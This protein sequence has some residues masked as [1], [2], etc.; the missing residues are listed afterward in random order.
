MAHL[1]TPRIRVILANGA[2]PDEGTEHIV[3]VLNV[4]M[5]AFDRDRG[6]FGWPD[7]RAAPMLW[8]TYLAWKALQRTGTLAQLPLAE[9]E[10]QALQVEM[11]PD[12]D[13]ADTVDPTQTDP[14][15]G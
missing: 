10:A 4:D 5:V 3:R 12:E 8:A 6:R 14:G 7:G 15:P 1:T 9:F 13:G 11:M 2:G